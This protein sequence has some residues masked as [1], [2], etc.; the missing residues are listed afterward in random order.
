LIKILKDSLA[1][2]TKVLRL[3]KANLSESYLNL[4]SS[5]QKSA[6][7]QDDTKAYRKSCLFCFVLLSA[8][9]RELIRGLLR[10]KPHK[11]LSVEEVL[12]H[13]WM[14]KQP[15][16]NRDDKNVSLCKRIACKFYL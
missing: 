10:I 6:F 7:N 9:C 4:F 12:A 13:A 16:L 3:H 15:P 14:K 5:F 11:R 8:E 1:F 2:S